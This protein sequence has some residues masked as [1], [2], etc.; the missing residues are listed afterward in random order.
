MNC[1]VVSDIK[2]LLDD[3]SVYPVTKI[4]NLIVLTLEKNLFD[5]AKIPVKIGI[6]KINTGSTISALFHCST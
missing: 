3:G 4:N 2:G 6:P 1:N 5:Y